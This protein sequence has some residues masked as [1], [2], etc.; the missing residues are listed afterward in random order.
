[1]RRL[2]FALLL[3]PAAAA[4]GCADPDLD[5]PEPDA[6]L[7][8]ATFAL[9]VAEAA[10]SSCSTSSV[11]GLSQQ[12]IAQSKCIHPDAF[13]KV[14]DLKNI[15]FNAPVFPYL[16]LP[17]KN[18]LVDA[19]EKHPGMN[20]TVISMLR[21]VAQQY[22]LYHWDL[23]ND[24]GIP[25][26]ATPGN[27]NHETGLAMDIGSYSSWR[28]ALEA[29][30]FDWYGPDDS[31][32]FDYQGA[33]AVNYKGTDVKAFQQLWNKNHPGDKIAED[34]D[35][36]PQ[37]EARLKKS[38]AGGFAI[39]GECGADGDG[40][41][42]GDGIADA[43]DNCP[44]DQNEG[45]L[46][47][48]GDGKGNKCDA[49]DDGDGVADADDNCKLVDNPGQIDSDGDG[50]GDA[51]Q[52]DNDG[53]G[54]PDADDVCPDVEDPEQE[55][56]DLDELGD[57]CDDDDDG[58]DTADDLDNCPT[59]ENSAQNDLDGDGLGDAC[60]DDADGDGIANDADGCPAVA[61][62]EQGD[63]DDD[64]IGDA[65]E[66]STLDEEDEADAPALQD[67]G[68]AVHRLSAGALP[69][70]S[71]ALVALALVAW[72]RRQSAPGATRRRRSS[73]V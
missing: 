9:T 71:L 7:G 46:D 54:T 22:L 27:S 6:R 3:A 5:G 53:D 18:A 62:V 57:A 32:H 47:T 1:M 45:Q 19:L 31:A 8:E 56:L 24:C 14:P 73:V 26:A 28:S 63:A 66:E 41:G 10:A 44:D 37:T 2:L 70:P 42:D 12:I 25:I 35:Y 40:D 58:D 61:D 55:N 11:K 21:T 17:A 64:G 38:P 20:L 51:C 49:D 30:G 59:V 16:E 52:D 50:K 36:G 72:R 65:C 68:C 33:G 15:S 4:I 48:D 13:V 67:G 43:Q 34:G 23:G 39:G 29:E 69:T 60:D